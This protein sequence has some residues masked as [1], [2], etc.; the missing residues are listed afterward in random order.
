MCIQSVCGIHKNIL[1]LK[2]CEL[3]MDLNLGSTL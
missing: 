1:F 3:E 2:Y